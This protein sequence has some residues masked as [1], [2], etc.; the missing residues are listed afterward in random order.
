M[1]LLR[2]QTTVWRSFPPPYFHLWTEP[3][4]K[5]WVNTEHQ[6]NTHKD[7]LLHEL[8]S[9]I[10]GFSMRFNNSKQYLSLNRWCV[11]YETVAETLCHLFQRI[12]L[13][14]LCWSQ[15]LPSS[16]YMFLTF[17]SRFM[18]FVM[19]NLVWQS[20]ERSHITGC[21]IFF[22]LGCSHLYRVWLQS[23]LHL[24]I[25]ILDRKCLAT[26]KKVQVMLKVKV[27]VQL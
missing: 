14:A 4:K 17:V 11:V 10:S 2:V 18:W 25:L 19:W 27:N 9:D 15:H 20:S 6:R 23:I 8:K 24:V 1:L 5:F 22:L 21:M 7:W 26:C 16:V 13:V 12:W 3:T